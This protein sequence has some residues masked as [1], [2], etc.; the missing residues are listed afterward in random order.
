MRSTGRSASSESEEES[1]SSNGYDDSSQ[2]SSSSGDGTSK[3]ENATTVAHVPLGQRLQEQDKRGG[4]KHALKRPKDAP[5]KKGRKSKHAPAEVSSRRRTKFD[6]NASGLS[7]EIGKH[8]YQPR[9]PRMQTGPQQHGSGSAE[10]EAF[11]RELREKEIKNIRQRMKAQKVPGK[12]GQRLRKKIGPV[13]IE[14]QA[15]LLQ[16][17]QTAAAADRQQT[18]QQ[19]AISAIREEKGRQYRPKVRE[20]REK[21]QASKSSNKKR[22]KK[23]KS[24]D[25]SLFPVGPN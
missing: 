3:S 21:I 7:V 23:N 22:K 5:K 8:R 14:E 13:D 4:I 18:R 12:K 15:S 19:A 16:R 17:L 25:S 9:D 1:T 6:I 2:S 24:K 20:L 10:S 11:F